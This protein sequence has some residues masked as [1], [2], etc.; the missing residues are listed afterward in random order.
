M[1]MQALSGAMWARRDGPGLLDGRADLVQP[2]CRAQQG[3]QLFTLAPG[4]LRHAFQPFSE[5]RRLHRCLRC[6][7]HSRQT[8]DQLNSSQRSTDND[9]S[10]F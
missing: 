1:P 4:E 3:E 9:D 8:A 2:D 7:L 5:A 6:Q 10:A